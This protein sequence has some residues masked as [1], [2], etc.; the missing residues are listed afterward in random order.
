MIFVE[1]DEDFSMNI[2]P[3]ASWSI[4]KPSLSTRSL[5]ATILLGIL[6]SCSWVSKQQKTPPQHLWA[7]VEQEAKEK[8]LLENLKEVQKFLEQKMVDDPLF[9]TVENIENFICDHLSRNGHTAHVHATIAPF[10]PTSEGQ[11][12][13]LIVS[14]KIDNSSYS[15]SL[16]SK[17]EDQITERLTVMVDAFQKELQISV[18]HKFQDVMMHKTD[19]ATWG[20]IAKDVADF[21][22]EE[23]WK[24][25]QHGYE[26]RW[27]TIEKNPETNEIEVQIQINDIKNEEI[28]VVPVRTFLREKEGKRENRGSEDGVS[29]LA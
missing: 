18:F 26:Y 19:D 5:Y 25:I 17:D 23:S 20:D 24:F 3:P 29:M 8:N 27:C 14:I 4:S 13:Y 6:S 2:L 21:L 1:Y 16:I 12:I 10:I 15:L 22:S 9:G 28:F 7:R 11:W